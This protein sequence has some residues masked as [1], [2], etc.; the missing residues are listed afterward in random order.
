L[1]HSGWQHLYEMT[2]LAFFIPP[3][4]TD[5]GSGERSPAG[6]SQS[7]SR[8]LLYK[9]NPSGTE[10]HPL[11]TPVTPS[12]GVISPLSSPEPTSLGAAGQ[13][14]FSTRKVSGARVWHFKYWPTVQA[15]R[16]VTGQKQELLFGRS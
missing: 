3:P 16:S 2:L 15:N 10:T 1:W 8:P 13:K 11:L 5:G 4:G 6:A 7:K 14:L 12:C 9:E